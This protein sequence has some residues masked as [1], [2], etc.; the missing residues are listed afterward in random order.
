MEGAY[1]PE[2]PVVFHGFCGNSL[3]FGLNE[4][5]ITRAFVVPPH[6]STSAAT[7]S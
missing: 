3:G 2:D 1:R 5:D 4:A 7:L 6:V